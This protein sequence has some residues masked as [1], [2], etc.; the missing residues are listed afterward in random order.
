MTVHVL[1][2]CMYMFFQVIWESLLT[3]WKDHLQSI[4]DDLI[5][6]SLTQDHIIS[7][8]TEQIA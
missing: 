4:Q 1:Y 2:V 6:S 7:K 3:E 8:L 5:G